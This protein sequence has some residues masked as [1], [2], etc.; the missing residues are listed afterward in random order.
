[1]WPSGPTTNIDDSL[2]DS[3]PQKMGGSGNLAPSEP[4]MLILSN[5]CHILKIENHTPL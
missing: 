1:M 2:E 4:H 5:L 3:G